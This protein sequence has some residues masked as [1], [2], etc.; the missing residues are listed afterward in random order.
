MIDQEDAGRLIFLIKKK[1]AG[2]I[3][4]HEMDE[5][6][7]V[8]SRVSHDKDLPMWLRST[9]GIVMANAVGKQKPKE[10]TA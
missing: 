3:T 6:V 9:L 5:L 10:L 8:L 1:K 4:P 2:L 7:G